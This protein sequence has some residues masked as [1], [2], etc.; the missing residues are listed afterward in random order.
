[1]N[2]LMLIYAF[3]VVHV[4]ISTVMM[5][6]KHLKKKKK[7]LDCVHFAYL[8]A[9]LSLLCLL[10]SLF[11]CFLSENRKSR[12]KSCRDETL[13]SL[14]NGL[15]PPPQKKKYTDTDVHS[16]IWFEKRMSRFPFL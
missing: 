2:A 3:C 14:S 12:R 6:T 10:L 15:Q 8:G 7:Y 16:S 5:R 1:M 4:F 9:I 13:L 11:C